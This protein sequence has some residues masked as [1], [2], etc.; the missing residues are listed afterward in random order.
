MRTKG[1]GGRHTGCKAGQAL[2][3]GP[4]WEG[5]GMSRGLHTH[6]GREGGRSLP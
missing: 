1:E 4:G 2:V 5:V 6:Q 3:W